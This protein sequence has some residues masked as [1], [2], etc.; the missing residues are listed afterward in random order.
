M[1]K[2]SDK[3]N[4]SLSSSNKNSSVVGKM[5]I[6]AASNLPNNQRFSL[7][8]PSSSPTV[9]S[10]LLSTSLS[11]N[12]NLQSYLNSKNLPH[13]QS[14]SNTITNSPIISS[15]HHYLSDLSNTKTYMANSNNSNYYDSIRQQ[16]D[17]NIENS[18][19]EDLVA[20]DDALFGC[21]KVKKSKN[22]STQ[23]KFSLCFS[24]SVPNRIISPVNVQAITT[25]SAAVASSATG[26]WN[27]TSLRATTNAYMLKY[28]YDA[29]FSYSDFENADQS[30][31]LEYYPWENQGYITA[32]SILPDICELI[33]KNFKIAVN[34]TY[35]T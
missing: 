1:I 28:A 30:L 18:D 27:M 15:G 24:K 16:F 17:N 4:N 23:Q 8:S 34:M 26:T 13:S 2:E 20:E 10:H 22:N 3:N 19:T 35:N 6:A 29:D 12:S 5:N 14:G 33:D 11:S 7:A 25:T 9:P 21:Y 32:F 31:K